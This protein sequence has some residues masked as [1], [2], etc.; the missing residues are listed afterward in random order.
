MSSITQSQYKQSH[1]QDASLPLSKET[2]NIARY[3][4][5]KFNFTTFYCLKAARNS[6]C[7][8]DV[9]S[10]THFQ[11]KKITKRRELCHL[12]DIIIR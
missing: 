1:H 9:D 12:R 4:L 10:T 2:E 3:L 6:I 7:V 8:V 11:I 5:S